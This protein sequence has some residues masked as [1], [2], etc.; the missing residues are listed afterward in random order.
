MILP[1]VPQTVNVNLVSS[2]VSSS[3]DPPLSQEFCCYDSIKEYDV[4]QKNKL[5]ATVICLAGCQIRYLER[6][7]Y[8]IHAVNMII[9]NEEGNML[10]QAM[11]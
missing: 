6:C 8:L 11:V 7:V 2:C 9:Y 1:V 4:F 10:V 5:I 3:S